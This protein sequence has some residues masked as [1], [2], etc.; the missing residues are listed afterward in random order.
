MQT[1]M[2]AVIIPLVISTF[3]NDGGGGTT[4]GFLNS[5]RFAGNTLGS[6]LDTTIL[7]QFGL[8]PSLFNDFNSHGS[9]ARGIS[10]LHKK[11][12]STAILKGFSLPTAQSKRIT[13]IR[14]RMFNGGKDSGGI[15]YRR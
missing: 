9:H 1:G 6:M 14:V 15:T 10:I 3:T 11:H 5:G 12:T 7:A 2:I 4:L 8:F 13:S